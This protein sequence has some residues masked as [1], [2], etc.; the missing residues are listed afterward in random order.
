MNK[1]LKNTSVRI[2]DAS[3]LIQKGL[4]NGDT[5]YQITSLLSN[6]GEAE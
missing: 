6:S 4:N 2:I 5:K 3:C 1:W